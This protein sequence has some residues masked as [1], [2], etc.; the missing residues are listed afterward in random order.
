MELYVNQRDKEKELYVS[1]QRDTIG[2][3]EQLSGKVWT[4]FNA[5]DPGITMLDV[6]NYG[7]T[8]LDYKQGFPLVDYLTGK[9][10]VFR[11]EELGLF[12]P[13]QVFPTN[14][15]TTDDY[16]KLFLMNVPELENVWIDVNGGTG[17]YCIHLEVFDFMKGVIGEGVRRRVE[18]LFLSHRNLC[19]RLESIDFVKLESVWLEGELDLLPGTDVTAVVVE[20]Y[21]RAYVYLARHVGYDGPEVMKQQAVPPDEWLD[22]PNDADIRISTPAKDEIRTESEL[23][24]MLRGLPGVRSLH[25]FYIRGKGGQ[26]VN[27]FER[28]YGLVVPQNLTELKRCLTVKVDGLPADVRMEH[29]IS[30]FDVNHMTSGNYLRVRPARRFAVDC[31]SGVWHPVFVHDSVADDFPDNY[32][33]N[34][35]GLSG[36]A[37]PERKA[38]AL[39]LKA[40]LSLFDFVFARGLRELDEL[41]RVMRLDDRLRYAVFSEEDFRTLSSAGLFKGEDVSAFCSRDVLKLK[42][43]LLDMLDGIYGEDSDP[44][45]LNEYNYYD[46]PEAMRVTRRVKFLEK[47]PLWGRDR[48]RAC[49]WSEGEDEVNIPG[50]K[51]YV[52]ALLDWPCDEG[53]AA[54]NIFPSYNLNYIRKDEYEQGLSRMLKADLIQEEMLS[55]YNMESVPVLPGPY[56]GEDYEGMRLA[57]PY[58]H[59]NLLNDELFRG[60]IYP[61]NFK[62][63]RVDQYESLLV[64]RDEERKVW[65]TLGR[66]PD[67]NKLG[68]MANILRDFLLKLNRESEAMYVV[69]NQYADPPV[70]FSLTIVLTGWSARMRHPRFREICRKLIVSRLPAHIRA[71]FRWLDIDGMQR[72]EMAWRQWRRC[73]QGG[74]GAEAA[75]AMEEIQIII[76]TYR[77]NE[78]K[79]EK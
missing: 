57:L 16:R 45:W 65:M 38:K 4:D 62:I 67:R 76:K 53:R 34:G 59:N 54:G 11:P 58:F 33:V 46:E 52:S 2:M 1:L 43:R 26:L 68:R 61:E 28:P 17:G 31:P 41:K 13:E 39:Q 42:S 60:G 71:D 22:G 15:V 7:L 72:F 51:A 35:N 24:R 44:E 21:H 32:G 3:L 23:Y 37:D 18:K 8:E 77:F 55:R 74:N 79:S 47:V 64:F 50:V 6:L 19:E 73:M 27:Y 69:E 14:P 25:S 66:S 5:H 49:N 48:F 75:V 56:T 70:Y 40:Y 9:E 36:F 63:V 12:L 20:M 30:A 29:F 10:E 78:V